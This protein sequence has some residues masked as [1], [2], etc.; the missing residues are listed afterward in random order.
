M[1][2]LY[3]CLIFQD[4]AFLLQDQRSPTLGYSSMFDIRILT[5]QGLAW[6]AR[7]H[8]EAL[9]FWKLS[10]C[11]SWNC[12]LSNKICVIFALMFLPFCQMLDEIIA[13]S[14]FQSSAAALQDTEDG[15]GSEGHAGYP[16]RNIHLRVRTGCHERN[17]CIQFF[18]AWN[19]E[20]KLHSE[21]FPSLMLQQ[22]CRGDHHWCRGWQK[23][24][25]LFPL[26][27]RQQ[28]D[29]TGFHEF[30]KLDYVTVHAGSE[31]ERHY[32]VWGKKMICC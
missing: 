31:T 12:V 6:L 18:T 30:F 25:W 22:V 32:V 5:E 10:K 19:I 20:E 9:H 16:S 14:L 27:P 26:H 21:L 11:L 13:L 23:G 1:Y 2:S 4:F 3:L 17:G 7:G 15:L 28:G 29:S 24:E 8:T